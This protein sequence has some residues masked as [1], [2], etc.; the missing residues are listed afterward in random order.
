MCIPG[1]WCCSGWLLRSSPASSSLERVSH[2]QEARFGAARSANLP[3]SEAQKALAE[4]QKALKPRPRPR[5]VLNV[6]PGER[7]VAPRERRTRQ[8]VSLCDPA[9]TV[10]RS[11][12]SGRKLS[13]WPRCW[14]CP[15][16]SNW[17]FPSFWPTAL[18]LVAERRRSRSPSR[19]SGRRSGH[20]L[21]NSPPQAIRSFRGLRSSGAATA[22]TRRSQRCAEPSMA[23]RA[24]QP[25]AESGPY[26]PSPGAHRFQGFFVWERTIVSEFQELQMS[27]TSSRN[28]QDAEERSHLTFVLT[29]HAVETSS[30]WDGT[31]QLRN[32]G[33]P[34]SFAIREQVLPCSLFLE[35][36]VPLPGAPLHFSRCAR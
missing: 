18:V 26:R 7:G 28:Q 16:G 15:C 22:E 14:A 11:W 23:C 12:G 9:A 25:G 32:Q 10:A 8:L 2:S 27:G 24:P 33:W 35:R 36:C 31:S 6:L 17:Q 30:A 19:S 21:G 5:R 13:N 34:V 4:A 29:M 1:C 20:H 3:R